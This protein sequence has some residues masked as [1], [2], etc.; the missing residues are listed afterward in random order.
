MFLFWNKVKVLLLFPRMMLVRR[1][2]S[3][4]PLKSLLCC[5]FVATSRPGSSDQPEGPPRRLD[6]GRH[7]PGVFSEHENQSTYLSWSTVCQWLLTCLLL[8][9]I[10]VISDRK[11]LILL[12]VTAFMKHNLPDVRSEETWL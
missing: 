4:R 12:L 11:C 6:E 7:H 10:A 5:C 2:C 3:D 8:S 9:N 1:G